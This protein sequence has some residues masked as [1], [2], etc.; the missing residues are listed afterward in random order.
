MVDD[1]TS[2]SKQAQSTDQAV[3]QLIS[4]HFLLV[5]VGSSHIAVHPLYGQCS[6]S[7]NARF[8]VATVLMA[9]ILLFCIVTL[10]SMVIDS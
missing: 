7:F 8:E 9:R 5:S 4:V 3:F 1:G 10:S 6:Q 2:H